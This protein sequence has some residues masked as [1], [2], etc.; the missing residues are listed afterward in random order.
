MIPEP[1]EAAL[2][3]WVAEHPGFTPCQHG[4]AHANHAVPGERAIE[5]GGHRPLASLLDDL[6][7][8]RGKLR[9]LFGA[10]LCDILVPPWN[11]ISP[12][13]VPHLDGLGY[14]ALSTIAPTRAEGA[15]PRLDCDLDIMDWRR[16][17]VGRP[18]ADVARAA[19]RVI[20]RQGSLGLL[21]HHLA[22]D[23]GAWAVLAPLAEE[24]ARHPAA[25]FAGQGRHRRRVMDSAMIDR[26]TPPER[27]DGAAPV[28]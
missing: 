2:A 3:A 26:A 13:L 11:R 24:F 14:A 5:L 6:V 1:A 23:A 18:L 17:R 10:R 19:A 16:G 15:I 22:H 4:F 8:G 12:A 21:T 9:A 25:R 27:A 7:R 28:R 20:D